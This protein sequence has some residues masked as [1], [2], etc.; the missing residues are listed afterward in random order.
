MINFRDWLILNEVFDYT[1]NYKEVNK[2]VYIDNNKCHSGVSTL[3][4]Y[5]K[6]SN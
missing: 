5:F 4:H 1:S 3:W 2:S 6:L